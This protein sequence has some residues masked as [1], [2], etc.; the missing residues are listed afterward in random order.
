MLL[1]GLLRPAAATQLPGALAVPDLSI[2]G[3]SQEQVAELSQRLRNEMTWSGLTVAAGPVLTD[4]AGFMEAAFPPLDA[5][6][7]AGRDL[8]TEKVVSGF[9]E[10]VPG[11]DPPVIVGIALRVTDVP[12]GV[13]VQYVHREGEFSFDHVLS[14]VLPG[15]ATEIAARQGGAALALRRRR[16]LSRDARRAVFATALG[17]TGTQLAVSGLRSSP[18][19]PPADAPQFE[20]LVVPFVAGVAGLAAG[21]VTGI[22]MADLFD[23]PVDAAMCAG[24]VWDR[25]LPGP[26]PSRALRMRLFQIP[27]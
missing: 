18:L 10:A 5:V 4:S 25:P 26:Q 27:L 7:R 21:V 24:A 1:A 19:M 6:L 23:R 9:A 8:G 2:P 20:R 12:S 15:M 16:E 17:I 14:A 22:W 11:T 3:L 13:H